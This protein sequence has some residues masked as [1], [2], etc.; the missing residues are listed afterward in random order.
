MRKLQLPLP[1]PLDRDRR[2][3]L[4]T[5]GGSPDTP[6]HQAIRGTESHLFASGVY[7][8][9]LKRRDRTWCQVPQSFSSANS[10][11]AAALARACGDSTRRAFRTDS[12][13]SSSRTCLQGCPSSRAYVA[14]AEARVHVAA[15][16]V[17]FMGVLYLHRVHLHRQTKISGYVIGGWGGTLH[18]TLMIALIPASRTQKRRV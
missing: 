11:A 9:I 14:D 7:Y 13:T 16:S 17:T 5:F 2:R 18:P 3:D 6:V 4:N 12:L 8:E 10:T 15:M 1:R